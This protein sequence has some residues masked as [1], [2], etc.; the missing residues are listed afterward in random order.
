[1][2]KHLLGCVLGFGLLAAACERNRDVKVEVED[3][4]EARGRTGEVVQDLEQRL[5]EAKAE[6]IRLEEK[7]AL[8]RQGV[9]DEVIEKRQ[10]LQEALKSQEAQVRNEV[11][12]AQKE[13]K[14]YNSQSAAARK[15][16]EETQPGQ[17]QAKIRTESIITPTPVDVEMQSERESIELERVNVSGRDEPQPSRDRAEEPQQVPQTHQDTQHQAVP[18]SQR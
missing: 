12:E 2:T 4:Q 18:E 17:A 9:T 7:L 8:A 14:E 3:L 5:E 10:D 13:A 1:M 11:S 16:L 15:Q 6:V